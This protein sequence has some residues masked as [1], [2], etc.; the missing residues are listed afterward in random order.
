MISDFDKNNDEQ[1]QQNRGRGQ[2][3]GVALGLESR[4][5]RLQRAWKRGC[6]MPRSCSGRSATLGNG[7]RRRNSGNPLAHGLDFKV[8][9]N[10]KQ[11]SVQQQQQQPKLQPA[12]AVLAR[13]VV[14]HIRHRGRVQVRDEAADLPS[15]PLSRH[16]ARSDL[17]P[18]DAVGLLRLARRPLQDDVAFPA[19]PDGRHF[20]PGDGGPE[21]AVREG[22]LLDPAC[23]D[24]PGAA[25][26]YPGQRRPRVQSSQVSRGEFHM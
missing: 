5:D 4:R 17:P 26:L 14:V 20:V 15:Q 12:E 10:L 2:L 19:R 24:R 3:L 22:D 16:V 8:K 23:A 11:Q 9:I 18:G 21:V 13:L 25:L 7:Y 6:R 1:Q